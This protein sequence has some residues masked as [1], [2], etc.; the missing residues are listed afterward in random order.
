MAALGFYF[1]AFF[2][3]AFWLA[4]TSGFEDRRWFLKLAVW[5]L[6][7]PWIAIECG[8]FVAEYWRLPW[9]VV[10]VLPHLAAASHLALRDILITLTGFVALYTVLA[11]IDVRLILAAVR[12]GP[13]DFKPFQPRRERPQAPIV[14]AESGG[15]AG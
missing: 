5:S 1:I 9:A 13:K 8:W 6:P 11:V 2:A 3:F 10:G 12:K 14:P 15:D 7:L 4:S